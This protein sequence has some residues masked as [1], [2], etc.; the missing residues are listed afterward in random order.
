MIEKI[1]TWMWQYVPWVY[2]D[3]ISSVLHSLAV[4]LPMILLSRPQGPMWDILATMVGTAVLILY[5]RKEQ[6]ESTEYREDPRIAGRERELKL[7]DSGIDWK[8]PTF[9]W[10]VGLLMT[11]L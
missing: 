11:W 6:T 7:R 4:L 8:W 10:V 3:G 1:K 9:A 2:K 5:H